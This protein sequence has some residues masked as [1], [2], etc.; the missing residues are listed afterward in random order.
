[1]I[2]VG[3]GEIVGSRIHVYL[4]IYIIDVRSTSFVE[5]IEIGGPSS[6]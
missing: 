4:I 3:T 5:E 2:D 1:M 6:A